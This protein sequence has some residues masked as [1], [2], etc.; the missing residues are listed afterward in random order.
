MCTRR[1][2]N[3][4]LKRGEGK[5]VHIRIKNR[6]EDEWETLKDFPNLTEQILAFTDKDAGNK[7]NIIVEPIYVEIE[8][9]DC[10]EITLIDLPGIAKNPLA[11]SEQVIIK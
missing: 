5:G 6:N 2:L 11:D 1:P 4:A 9:E 3:L 8:K 10:P 7:G